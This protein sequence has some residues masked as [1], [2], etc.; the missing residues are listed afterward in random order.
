MSFVLSDQKKPD[1]WK[2]TRL[3]KYWSCYAEEKKYAIVYHFE[4][5]T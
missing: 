3:Y 2:L 4:I 1:K 5:K